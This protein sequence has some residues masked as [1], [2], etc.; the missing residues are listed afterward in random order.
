MADEQNPVSPVA[1][2]S[3]APE[4]PPPPPPGDVVSLEDIDAILATEDPEFSQS[5]KEISSDTTIN[6]N[7]ITVEGG[8]NEDFEQTAATWEEKNPRLARL[9]KPVFRVLEF[10]SFLT[11]PFRFLAPQLKRFKLYF[12]SRKMLLRNWLIMTG[13]QIYHFARNDLPRISLQALQVSRDYFKF[14]QSK[15][16]KFNAKPWSQKILFFLAAAF[17]VGSFSILY[18]V[19]KGGLL[20]Q[21]RRSELVDLAEQGEKVHPFNPREDLVLFYTAFP[22]PE[23]TVLLNKFIVNLK[24]E[25]GHSNPMSFLQLYLN[26]DS[27][28]TAIEVKDREKEFSDNIQRL[29]EDFTYSEINSSLGEKKFKDVVRTEVNRLLNQGRIKD[30][31]IQH[32][33]TKP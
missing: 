20:N 33:V 27:Q 14:Q 1:A 16:R 30:V 4:A 10:F 19:F 15:I 11:V 32:K 5:I 7:T 31:Y 24:P 12:A 21:I 23:F 6:D 2:G 3:P 26:C 28:E 17:A 22:Q 9:L 13:K 8:L 25:P 29:A 18:S